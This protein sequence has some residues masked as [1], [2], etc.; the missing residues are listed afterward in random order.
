MQIILLDMDGVLLTPGGYHRA[1]QDA[2]ARM[3]R[4]LGFRSLRLSA[5]ALHALEA[6]G[7]TNEWDTAAICLALMAEQLWSHNPQIEISTERITAPIAEHDLAPP[8]LEAFIE[9]MSAGPHL[10]KPPLARAAGLLPARTHPL[11]ASAHSAA[12]LSHR[13]QQEHVLGSREFARSYRLRPMLDLP[14]Y[15][16]TYDRSNLSKESREQ[17]ISWRS[18]P[19][20]AAIIFTN[21]PSRPPDGLFGTPEAELGR[22]VVGLEQLPLMAT[23]DILWLERQHNQPSSTYNKPHP[24]H[25][26]AALARGTGETALHALQ[27]AAGLFQGHWHPFWEQFDQARVSVLEDAAGGINSL[28]AAAAR[29]ASGGVSLEL[30]LIGVARQRR[31]QEALR[32]A[33]AVVFAD[34]GAALQAALAGSTHPAD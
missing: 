12:S 30:D 13:L 23:G 6:C 21:R 25:A 15:L 32:R 26:L 18:R 8:D 28:Q 16:A 27:R 31:K 17:L 5:D 14:S 7:V 10:N 20:N 34:L 1:V 19:G 11:L 2:V 33:G 3:G 24:I 9:Q 4:M 29:L 22:Q